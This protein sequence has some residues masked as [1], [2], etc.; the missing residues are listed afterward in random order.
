[1]RVRPLSLCIL[2]AALLAAGGSPVPAQE[3]PAYPL[4]S[5]L[6][7]AAAGTSLD[8]VVARI[9]RQY[10]ARVVRADVREEKGRKVYV[11]RLLDERSGRVWTVRVDAESGRVL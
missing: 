9:E 1:M 4:V 2:A 7:L 3:L 10:R 5:R 11:L 8:D 6:I